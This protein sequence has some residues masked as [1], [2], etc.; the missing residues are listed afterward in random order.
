MSE[1]TFRKCNRCKGKDISLF[2]KNK[3]TGAILKTCIDCNEKRSIQCKI[4]RKENPE[5]NKERCKKYYNANKEI[6]NKKGKIYRDNNKETI[7]EMKKQWCEKNKE[8]CKE[9][10]KRY[11]KE[12]TEKIKEKTKQWCKDNTEKLKKYKEENRTHI[13]E[14][15]KKYREE[16]K[17]K[18]SE[19]HTK[20]MK[21]YAK[22]KRHHC[23][24]DIEKR[25]CKICDPRG[26]L[27]H[28]VQSRVKSA[29][30]A[31]KSK[32]TIEYLG[33]D[34]ETFRTHLEKT[35][36]EGMG[37]HNYGFGDNKWNIDHCIPVLY[38]QDGIKPSI[39]EVG[40]RLHYTN[41][42][43]MWQIENLSKGNRY[44]G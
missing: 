4:Y 29:L 25:T 39:E 6:A 24:H 44:I 7:K 14:R 33:C 31:D 18:I 28:I 11:Y 26:H 1:S 21:Q 8:H 5:K 20:Y 22:D 3:K 19:Y 37:W 41:C 15:K 23:E 40:N 9:K 36:K 2:G 30:K 32:T 27:K 43:A 35:F 34:I 13:L 12:N 16:N 17:E 42:Q 10:N 38:E